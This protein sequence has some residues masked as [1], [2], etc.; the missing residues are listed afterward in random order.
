MK[1]VDEVLLYDEDYLTHL[2]RIHEF[3]SRCRKHGITLNAEKFTL[4]TLAVSFC[5]YVLSN[6]GKAVDPEKDKAI[7]DFTTPASLTDLRSFMG[8]VNQLAE[9]FPD[10][11]AAAQLL[12]PLMSPKRT[13]V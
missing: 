10:I 11:S 5:G 7:A 3:L 8:L 13:F 4:T 12:R 2:Y 9:F 6:E 1:L